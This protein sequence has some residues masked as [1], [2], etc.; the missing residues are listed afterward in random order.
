MPKTSRWNVQNLLVATWVIIPHSLECL[1]YL[2][3][4]IGRPFGLLLVYTDAAPTGLRFGM[5]CFSTQISPL[6]G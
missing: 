3:T 6:R 1:L 5:L 2:L 4:C